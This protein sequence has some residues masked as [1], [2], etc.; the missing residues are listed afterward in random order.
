MILL[1][2]HSCNMFSKSSLILSAVL[3]SATNSKSIWPFLRCWI[4]KLTFLSISVLFVWE[5]YKVE[6][7]FSSVCEILVLLLYVW[8]SCPYQC[9]MLWPD[10]FLRLSEIRVHMQPD[11]G[12]LLWSLAERWLQPKMNQHCCMHG[13]SVKQEKIKINI[14]KYKN[15]CHEN[16]NKRT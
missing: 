8:V 5:M 6:L 16:L 10:W 7:L 2:S 13:H 14:N 11:S 3:S 15:S 9:N 4:L 12:M 1:L